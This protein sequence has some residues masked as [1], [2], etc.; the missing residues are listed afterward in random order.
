MY[1]KRSDLQK[2]DTHEHRRTHCLNWGSSG[3]RFKSCQPD[4]FALVNKYF[5]L[6]LKW[7]R[8]W[9]LDGTLKFNLLMR[10]LER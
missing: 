9:S 8:R 3:R 4:K 5:Y 10:L 6:L 2:L 7:S 1:L